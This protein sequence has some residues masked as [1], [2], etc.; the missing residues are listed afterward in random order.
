MRFYVWIEGQPGYISAEVAVR[1]LR[2]P[3]EARAWANDTWI[4]W[5]SQSAK[6]ITRA[7][8]LMRPK[9]REALEAWER[10][11]DG[12]MQET[13]GAQRRGE[14]R[15]EAASESALGCTVANAALN[16]GDPEAIEEAVQRHGHDGCGW[17][18]PGEPRSRHLHPVS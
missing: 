1:D 6:I 7:E 16:G 10:G 5:W 12:V 11:D 18:L 15:Q 14:L 2:G 17:S 8:A 3:D 13:E 9:Y 4:P